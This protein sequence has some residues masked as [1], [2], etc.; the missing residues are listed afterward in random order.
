MALT[1][2]ASVVARGVTILTALVSVPLTVKYLGTERYGMW[3]TASSVIALLGFADFGMGNGLLNA[4]SEAHGKDDRKTAHMYVSSAFFMLLGVAAMILCLFALSYS[5]ISW[6]RVFNVT[7][8][9]AAQE[10][11]PAMAVFVAS[12]AMNMP[13]GVAQRV[14]MG[15]QEGL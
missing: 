4:V 1:S 7:S 3:M 13:L 15:Y 9:L 2:L 8:E 6:P 14:Q 10:A 5:F 11:G 12:L